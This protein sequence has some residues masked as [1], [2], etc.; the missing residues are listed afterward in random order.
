[1][2]ILHKRSYEEEHEAKHGQNKQ[3]MGFEGSGIVGGVELSSVVGISIESLVGGC[4]VSCGANWWLSCAW[5]GIGTTFARSSRQV[6]SARINE[7]AASFDSFAGV[8]Q[9]NGGLYDSWRIGK[10][11]SFLQAVSSSGCGAG[12]WDTLYLIVISILWVASGES[13]GRS[14]TVTYLSG[15]KAHIG[16]A[17]IAFIVKS[18]FINGDSLVVGKLTSHG[19]ASFPIISLCC[20]PETVG[21]CAGHLAFLASDLGFE[22]IAVGG[23]QA[24]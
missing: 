3:L 22:C 7:A 6:S 14:C 12:A 13:E 24:N 2:F 17:S 20:Q 9:R 18:T 5:G 11:E 4:F 8:S 15:R 1:M 16:G 21:H 23:H 19:W 10:I